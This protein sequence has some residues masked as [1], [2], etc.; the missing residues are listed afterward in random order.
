MKRKN[1]GQKTIV[2]RGW[3]LPANFNSV[4]PLLMDLQASDYNHCYGEC[5]KV[6][7]KVYREHSSLDLA[8]LQRLSLEIIKAGV[9]VVDLMCVGGGWNFFF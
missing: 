7:S 5:S 8:L 6:Y 9:S 4:E 2:R 1:A 3:T